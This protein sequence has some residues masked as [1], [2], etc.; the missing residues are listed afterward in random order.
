MRLNPHRCASGL[1]GAPHWSYALNYPPTVI[2]SQVVQTILC[3][4]RCSLITIGTPQPW[5]VLLD[6]ILPS[7]I[8]ICVLRFSTQHSPPSLYSILGSF[9]TFV[10][11]YITV[12]FKPQDD[13]QLGNILFHHLR[14]SELSK[15][16]L[17]FDFTLYSGNYHLQSEVVSPD[18]LGYCQMGCY[19]CV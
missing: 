1:I 5:L 13:L 14:H 19:C 2:I 18:P 17:K 4:E 7:Y 8:T 15:M 3:W 12:A 10:H 16:T 11:K 6:F 9:S